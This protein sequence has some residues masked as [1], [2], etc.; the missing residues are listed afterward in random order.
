MGFGVGETFLAGLLSAK[1]TVILYCPSPQHAYT[2]MHDQDQRAY[3][4]HLHSFPT[5]TP[6][7]ADRLDVE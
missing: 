7:L 6:Q 5:I 3:E 2:H 1:P 4:T